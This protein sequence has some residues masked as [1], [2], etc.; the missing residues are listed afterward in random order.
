LAQADPDNATWQRQLA[1]SHEKIGN[2]QETQTNLP[3]SLANYE[4]SLAIRKRL[5][6]TSSSDSVISY[7][8]IV[9]FR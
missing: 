3:A 8:R 5:F 2:V 9:R 1:V 6:F 7:P 4:S